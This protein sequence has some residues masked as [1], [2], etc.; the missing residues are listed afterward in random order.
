M[1]RYVD[2]LNTRCLL[3]LVAVLALGGCTRLDGGDVLPSAA[4]L[5]S[6]VVAQPTTGSPVLSS[7]DAAWLVARDTV[8]IAADGGRLVAQS[9]GVGWDT[10]ALQGDGPGE[11]RGTLWVLATDGGTRV[12]VDA[13]A[14][15][16][17]HWAPSGRFAAS[18]ALA[19]ATITGAWVMADALI[20]RYAV[21]PTEVRIVRYAM[22]GDSLGSV[23]LPAA[24][25]SSVLGCGHCPAAVS[26]SGRI[27]IA[28]S[29]TTY[30][31]VEYDWAGQPVGQWER[32]TV[33]L[34]DHDATEIDS[35]V[36]LWGMVQARVAEAGGTD[37]SGRIGAMQRY[38]RWHKRFLPRGLHFA[39]DCLLAQR[40]VA[41]GD[42]A[43]VDVFDATRRFRGLLRMAPGSRLQQAQAQQLLTSHEEDDGRFSFSVIEWE[44]CGAG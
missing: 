18:F 7:V 31:I 11:V 23:Q 3:W 44:G 29:D 27:A 37:V 13:S 10:L 40:T 2:R 24:L 5:P 26:A 14:H 9:A 41:R 42:S 15:R 34:V 8:L 19:P 1:R 35:L 21:S 32:A 36:R 4:V 22:S 43:E 16:V 30:R 12:G 28:V 20:V 6:R 25:P 39:G 17:Q 38:S 33:R